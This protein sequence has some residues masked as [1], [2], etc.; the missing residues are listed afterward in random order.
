LIFNAAKDAKINQR[1]TA[2]THHSTTGFPALTELAVGPP[3]LSDKQ[4][5]EL[6]QALT[7]GAPLS[8]IVEGNEWPS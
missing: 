1:A 8:A 5:D 7:D 2:G 4:V 6:L 3:E